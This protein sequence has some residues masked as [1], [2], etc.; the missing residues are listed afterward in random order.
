MN[1]SFNGQ[2]KMYFVCA[3]VTA[4]PLVNLFYNLDTL[5]AILKKYC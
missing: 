2:R 4:K 1:L 3:I 5:Q